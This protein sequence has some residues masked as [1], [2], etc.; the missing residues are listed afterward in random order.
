[1]DIKGDMQHIVFVHGM[2][3]QNGKY[4]AFFSMLEEHGVSVHSVFLE[5]YSTDGMFVRFASKM[6]ID[7]TIGALDDIKRNTG[8]APWL[9]ASSLGSAWALIVAKKR[10]DLIEGMILH[11]IIDIK[12]LPL[13]G[14]AQRFFYR[15][16]KI[17]YFLTPLFKFVY[18]PL[19]FLLGMKARKRKF[20]QA[21]SLMHLFLDKSMQVDLS[22]ILVP[23]YLI[24]GQDDKV[25]QK[26][27]CIKCFKSLGNARDFFVIEDGGHE[28]LATSPYDLTEIITEKIMNKLRA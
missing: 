13:K 17:F 7:Q 16:G 19:P 28:I 23:S 26:S 8:K 9:F 1:L 18:F 10:P 14:F 3:G 24:C 2:F 20:Y 4:K 27:Y 15:L 21:S 11:T 5:D 6:I 12:N 25:L 22:S